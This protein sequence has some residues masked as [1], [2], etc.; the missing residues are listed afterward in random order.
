MNA[1]AMVVVGTTLR[2]GMSI[3]CV[4]REPIIL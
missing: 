1:F 2:A 3:K 4:N